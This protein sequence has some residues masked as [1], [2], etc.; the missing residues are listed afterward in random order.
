[1]FFLWLIFLNF[2]LFVLFATSS[3]KLEFQN[4]IISF[5]KELVSSNSEN[6]KINLKIYL[7]KR[8]KIF[9]KNLSKIKSKS[10]KFNQIKDLVL[11]F[12]NNRK[13]N[14]LKVT[15][16]IKKLNFSFEKVNLEVAVGLED[17]A[18]AALTVGFLYV[19]LEN[20]FIRKTQNLKKCDIRP[21]YHRN[22]L[23]LKFD[24]I[25][26]IDM[27]NIINIILKHN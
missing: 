12:K 25:F 9:S 21:V 6:G 10:L 13:S 4:F 20:I 26:S 23:W 3:I 15:K 27:W 18:L 19:F 8:V 2:L 7:F 24:G 5:P 1:M 17:A 16:V 14:K 11:K 22:V